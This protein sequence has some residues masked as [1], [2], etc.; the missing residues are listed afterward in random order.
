MAK[1]AHP[2]RPTVAAPWSLGFIQRRPVLT[3]YAVVFA[4]SWGGVLLVIGG[5]SG[6]PGT[7]EEFER[8][9]PLAIPGLLLGPAI[10]GLLVTGLVDGRAGFRA[11]WSRLVRWRVGARWYA[12]ALLAAPL[13]TL[14]IQLP[15]AL[16][17]PAFIPGLVTTA[18]RGSFLLAGLM[19]GLMVG[20]LEEIGWTGFA[21]PRLRLR[22]GVLATGLI[23]GLLWG[24]WHL[25]GHVF[26]AAEISAGGLP[27]GPFVLANS[28][29]MVFGG[30]P[31]FR[32]L[33][34]WVYD[35]TDSL[36][37]GMFMHVSYTASTFILGPGPQTI[38]GT[39][40]LIHGLVSAAVLW[41]VVAAVTVALRRQPA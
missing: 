10:A 13:L 14:A 32:V 8:L 21:I 40:L 11:L 22:H 3:F 37:L 5:P 19:G 16:T 4:I 25:L 1:L 34:V 23:V 24:V 7:P 36:L 2:R 30:L 33:M 9:L 31:A 20:I 27:L 38:T 35:R 6:I 39:A 18:D 15:L 12:V 17:S 41:G 28:V 26:W 29:S